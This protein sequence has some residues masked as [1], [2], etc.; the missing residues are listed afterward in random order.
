MVNFSEGCDSDVM[1]PHLDA[2]IGGCGWLGSV[3]AYK[4]VLH[5]SAFL[6]QHAHLLQM[7]ETQATNSSTC[8][9]ALCACLCAGKLLMLLQQGK[10]MVQEGALTALASV[11]DCSQEEFVRYYDSVMPLLSNIMLNAQQKEHR[12]GEKGVGCRQQCVSLPSSF[13]AREGL[14]R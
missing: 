1:R 11:A 5:A 10:R 12:W 6:R 9:F 3:T 2:L 13:R 4:S 7:I 14:T 8:D